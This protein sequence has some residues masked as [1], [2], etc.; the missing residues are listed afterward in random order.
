VESNHEA[1]LREAKREIV[2]Q[3]L[4]SGRKNRGRMGAVTISLL[5]AFL[6]AASGLA[7]IIVS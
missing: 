5:T 2:Q 6:A 4:E 3:L 1:Q 7:L